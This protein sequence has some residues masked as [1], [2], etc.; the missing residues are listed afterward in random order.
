MKHSD[1]VSADWVQRRVQW[2]RALHDPLRQPLNTSP[3]LAEVRR[4]QAQ[5]L[6]TSFSDLLAD[7]HTRPAATFF[8]SDL[9]ADR[10]FTRRD[11]SIATV[12]PL[13]ARWLPASL[14]RALGEAVTLGAL[15]HALDLRVVRALCA[16]KLSELDPQ[17]Y[18]SAYRSAGCPRLRGYQIDLIVAVGQTL[19]RAVHKRGVSGLLRASRVPAR[20]AGVVPLQ[21]FL[22]RGFSAFAALDGASDFLHTIATRERAVSRRLFAGDPQPFARC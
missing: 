19:D 20:L 2:H 5:R 8:L 10:D 16:Q 6:A 22:E 3:W 21:Q 11:Q 14:L 15:S 7:Q 18:A 17:R 13:M 4:W 9:Y 12:V 1:I